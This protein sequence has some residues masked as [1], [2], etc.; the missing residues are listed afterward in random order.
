MSVKCVFC[1]CKQSEKSVAKVKLEKEEK[2]QGPPLTLCLCVDN[3]S[4]QCCTLT[5]CQSFSFIALSS[6]PLPIIHRHRMWSEWLE[7]YIAILSFHWHEEHCCGCVF[8]QFS[9][10]KAGSTLIRAG[11]GAFFWISTVCDVVFTV[12]AASPAASASKAPPPPCLLISRLKC[13]LPCCLLWPQ[14]PLFLLRNS[15]SSRT[16]THTTRQI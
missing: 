9:I 12:L 2:N 5:H 14:F 10:C 6:S 16:H 11:S 15:G 1:F 7:F 3:E 4:Q 8:I 13:Q